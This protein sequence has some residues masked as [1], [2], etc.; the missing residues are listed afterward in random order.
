MNDSS[1]PT[2]TVSSAAK[3]PI[4]G[5]ADRESERRAIEPLPVFEFLL[6]CS[7][8]LE[9][10]RMTAATAQIYLH[11]CRRFLREAPKEEVEY[12]DL[13][14]HLMGAA[15]LHLACKSTETLRKVR[16]L[17]NVSYLV[18]NTKQPYLNLDDKYQRMRDS[19][20]AAEL[21]VLRILQFDVNVPTPHIWVSRVVQR[22]L[23]PD[24]YIENPDNVSDNE[25]DEDDYNNNCNNNDDADSNSNDSK[26][27]P[28]SRQPMARTLLQ[29]AWSYANDS[30]RSETLSLDYPPHIVALA[31]TYTAIR[32]LNL[33]LP[34]SFNKWCASWN[35][36]NV[37]QVQAAIAS[38]STLYTKT[39]LCTK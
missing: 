29:L 2:T 3:L 12:I 19:L 36:S 7:D 21:A 8:L 1:T 38:I 20:V 25:D 5:K 27:L 35:V 30:M 10:P 31:C 9:L 28:P 23:Q 17:I 26:V 32:V 14:E 6:I 34:V 16:D 39:S 13:D 22:L 24:K 4:P 15:C 33:S 11:Q 18:L 37:E